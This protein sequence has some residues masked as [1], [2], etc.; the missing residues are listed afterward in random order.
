MKKQVTVT[1]SWDDGDPLDLRVIELLRMRGLPGTF[2]VPITG[3]L[4]RRTLQSKEMREMVREK[5]EIGA[6]SYSHRSLERL[7]HAELQREVKYCRTRLEESVGQP[8]TMFCYP[9][10]RYDHATLEFVSRTGYNGA[11]TT[12]MLRTDA[13]DNRFEIPTTVQAYPHPPITYVKNALKGHNVS[14]LAKLSRSVYMS[15]N[16][17]EVGMRTFDYVLRHGGVWHLYGHS[18][19]LEDFRL[20]EGL[21]TLLDYVAQ[22]DGVQ[23]VTN[24]EMV[25]Q[26]YGERYAPAEV[27][28]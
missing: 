11:R 4:G 21:R 6:H 27:A 17:I 9:N 16:W 10:G 15:A 28:A 5:F 25:A 1:T 7:E 13:G 20:W 22:R 2:Y 12:R 24:G 18:W 8:V 14:A 23:Y 3:Y 26:V 19:E